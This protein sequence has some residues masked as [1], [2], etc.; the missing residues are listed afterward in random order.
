MKAL[1]LRPRTL[2]FP[3]S[4]GMNEGFAFDHGISRVARPQQRVKS[5]ERSHG[6]ASQ[7]GLIPFSLCPDLADLLQE[8][9]VITV[10]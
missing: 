6:T 7:A 4:A 1:T 10:F 2:A 9:V 3:S 5:E 8:P